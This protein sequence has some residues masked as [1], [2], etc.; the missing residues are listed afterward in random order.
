VMAVALALFGTI[1]ALAIHRGAW[2]LR[3]EP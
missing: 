3:R 2:R 1:V